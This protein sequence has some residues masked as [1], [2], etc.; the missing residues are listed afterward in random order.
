MFE[1]GLEVSSQGLL[2]YPGDSNLINYKMESLIF[3]F[4]F[5]ESNAL[6]RKFNL[7]CGLTNLVMQQTTG[8][9][10]GVLAYL[11]SPEK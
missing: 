10:G 3:L 8:D 9:Y 2:H 6:N 11:K 5:D 1:D 4:K 7:N